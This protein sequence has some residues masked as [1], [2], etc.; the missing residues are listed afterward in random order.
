M[1]NHFENFDNYQDKYQ[2]ICCEIFL[3][4][5]NFKLKFNQMISNLERIKIDDQIKK[6][7]KYIALQKV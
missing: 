1:K 6:D 3:D 2:Q 7:K 4:Q 5:K